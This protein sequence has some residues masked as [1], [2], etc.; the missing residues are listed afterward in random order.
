[1]IS[2]PEIKTILGHTVPDAPELKSAPTRSR[3]PEQTA[4]DLGLALAIFL[5]AVAYLWLFR[6]YTFIEPDEGIILQGAQR[7]LRGEVLYRDFFS[8]FTPGSYY[9]VALL[10]KVFGSS[11]LV[12]RTALVFFGGI[13][14]VIS[15]LLA[16]RVCSRGNALWVAAV[17]ALIT[18]PYRFE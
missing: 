7:I 4:I 3:L 9:F 13:Y 16:R 6:R 14:S 17:V 18:I 1:M 15:Y 11:F 2:P 8:F 5:L 12:A 10:F